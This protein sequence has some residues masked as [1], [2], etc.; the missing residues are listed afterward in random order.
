MVQ[1]TQGSEYTLD[2]GQLSHCFLRVG[3]L[4]SIRVSSQVRLRNFDLE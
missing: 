3:P 4:L 2:R 1:W